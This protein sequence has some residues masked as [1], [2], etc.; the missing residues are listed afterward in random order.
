MCSAETCLAPPL[1]WRVHSHVLG[2]EERK[3]MSFVQ[4]GGADLGWYLRPGSAVI[5]D[6]L[7]LDNF[8]A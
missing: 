7:S 5:S 8:I 1:K 4:V 3:P 6:Y 2:H